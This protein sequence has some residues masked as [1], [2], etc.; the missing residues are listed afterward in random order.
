M[1][2][3]EAANMDA[4]RV[5]Y[6][7]ERDLVTPVDRAVEEFIVSEIRNRYPDH[8]IYGEETGRSGPGSGACWVIDP[9]DGTTSFVH[10]LPFYSVSI[11]FQKDDQTRIGAVYAPVLD[12]LFFAEKSC[13]A[14]LNGRPI[15]V[16]KT[17]RLIHALVATGFACIRAGWSRNNLTY[18]NRILPRIRDIRRTGSAA[19]DLC[20]V[21]CGRFDGFWEMNLNLYDIAAGA[22][23]VTEAGG[24]MM[25]FNG[26]S[27]FPGSG[28]IAVNRALETAFLDFF[29]HK[30]K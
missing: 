28:T 29:Q 18:L 13:G 20:Y 5:G 7:T 8:D 22:L 14:F 10:G 2:V 4:G 3:D 15:R 23:I 16:S 9:I 27:D 25:D 21:A 24:R 26:G 30:G 12:E 1:T 11:A 6:K 17:D 19:L